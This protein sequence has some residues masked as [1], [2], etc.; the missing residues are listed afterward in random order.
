MKDLL[1]IGTNV[2]GGGT[3]VFDF[4]NDNIE[5]YAHVGMS[6]GQAKG[7]SYS[8]GIVEGYEGIGDCSGPFVSIG[9]GIKGYGVD[10]CFD[11]R[12]PHD[13]T[14]R[15]YSFTFGNGSSGYIGFNQYWSI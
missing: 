8:V 10:H 13:E 15:A 11:P 7:L 6:V 12:K 3:L 14:V 1:F 4:K 2:K 5:L 9:G